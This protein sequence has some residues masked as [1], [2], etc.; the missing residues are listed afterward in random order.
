MTALPLKLSVSLKRAAN[1]S[2]APDALQ[3]PNS[4]KAMPES[5]SVKIHEVLPR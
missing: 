4:F 1:D 2:R 5:R 3:H